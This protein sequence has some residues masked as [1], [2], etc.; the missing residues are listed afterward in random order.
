[1]DQ[2]AAL[3]A[4]PGPAQTAACAFECLPDQRR[5]H[6]A[7]LAHTSPDGQLNAGFRAGPAA[8]SGWCDPGLYLEGPC[9]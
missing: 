7:A 8:P 5:L 3:V 6:G 9:V 2:L 1:V 4:G